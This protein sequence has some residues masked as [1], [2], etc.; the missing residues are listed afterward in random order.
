MNKILFY[1]YNWCI[2]L[3]LATDPAEIYVYLLALMI[4]LIEVVQIQFSNTF[5]KYCNYL[6]RPG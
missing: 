6:F 5:M 4:T 1:D 3:I 2:F